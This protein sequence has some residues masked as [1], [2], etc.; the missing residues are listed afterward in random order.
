MLSVGD[1]GGGGWNVLPGADNNDAILRALD[2]TS[3]CFAVCTIRRL[4]TPSLI[5]HIVSSKHSTSNTPSSLRVILSS[6]HS[7]TTVLRHML[8]KPVDQFGKVEV[9][10]SS[11][12]E[13]C[14]LSL[15]L[16]DQL[17]LR[18]FTKPEYSGWEEVLTK[19]LSF[20][21]TLAVTLDVLL[22]H[23]RAGKY[24]RGTTL[25]LRYLYFQI[26]N[27]KEPRQV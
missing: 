6:L 13:V 5:I 8:L 18:D 14:P 3:R 21:I 2:T 11:S 1:K 7:P 27:K 22:P 24:W 10:A 16:S 26:L 19:S 17:I 12:S 20:R 15:P 9:L 4:Y 25:A 23:I